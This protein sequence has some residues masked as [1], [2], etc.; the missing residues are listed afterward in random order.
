[1]AGGGAAGGEVAQGGNLGLAP[2]LCEGAAGVEDA[3]GGR[4]CGAGDLA[5]EEGAGAVGA[6]DRLG[7]GLEEGPGVGV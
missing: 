5:L 6:G 3:T 2:G 4:V 7:G 1:M